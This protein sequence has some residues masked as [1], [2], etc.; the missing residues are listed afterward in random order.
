MEE[1]KETSMSCPHL[2]E[3]V[4]MFCGAC[5]VKKMLP[6]DRLA[7]VDPCLGG[8]FQHCELFMEL[9]ARL[10]AS[11]EHPPVFTAGGPQTGV[12]R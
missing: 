6:L 11:P 12:R 1:A 7:S 3:V 8:D 10:K 5:P 4:M 2:K 9:S